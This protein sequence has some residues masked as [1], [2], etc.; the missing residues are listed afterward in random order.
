EIFQNIYD[1]IKE[2]FDDVVQAAKDLPGRIGDGIKSM[3][4]KVK[5]GVASVVNT[6]GGLLESG[7]NGVI[8]GINW[9]L[10]KIGVDKSNQISRVSIP[11]YAQGTDGHPQDGLAWV[12][13]GKGDNAGQELIVQP[14]GTMGMYGGRNVLAYLEKGTQVISAKNTRRML[15]SIPAYQDGKGWLNKAWGAVKSGAGKVKDAAVN[16]WDYM[17]N[18][19]KLL[20]LALKTLGVKIPKGGSFV[21]NIAK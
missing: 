19:S 5:E 17:N 2:K 16:V 21:G 15:E 3:A 11:E 9:V 7:M 18:P 20:D 13:D 1:S 14:D 6:M 8:D 12:N 4:S 10:D